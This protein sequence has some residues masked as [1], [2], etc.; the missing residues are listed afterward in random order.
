MSFKKDPEAAVLLLVVA[1]TVLL[2]LAM[3]LLL[4]LPALWR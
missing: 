4:V 3:A 2:F 1:G